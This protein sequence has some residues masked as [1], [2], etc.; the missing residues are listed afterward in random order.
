M[1]GAYSVRPGPESYLPPAAALHGVLPPEP[2]SGL[3]EGRSAPESEV[4]AHIAGKLLAAKNPTFFPGPQLLWRTTDYALERGRLTRAIAEI[5]RARVIPMPDYRPKY[6]MIDPE[7]EINPNHPN[8]TIWHNKIDVGVFIGVH[9]HQANMALKIIRG[10]TPCYTIALCAEE[11]HEEAHATLRNT[12][13][14]KLRAVLDA[15]RAQEQ[16]W[17]RAS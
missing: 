1:M 5:V 10:G 13:N 11:G 12:D 7:R 3:I 6:P 4:I 8:L 17:Q 9:C 2:G 14:T 16:Q 15:V